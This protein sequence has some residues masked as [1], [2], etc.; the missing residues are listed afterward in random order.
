MTFFAFDY[1]QGIPMLEDQ[2]VTGVK[3][4]QLAG[5]HLDSC[6]QL[7]HGKGSNSNK[8]RSFIFRIKIYQI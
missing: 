3:I 2:I 6:G 1:L 8:L 7:L 5:H 4:L